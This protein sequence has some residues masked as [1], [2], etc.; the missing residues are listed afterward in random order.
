M[1][2]GNGRGAAPQVLVVGAGPV[3]LAAALALRAHGVPVTVLEAEPKDR[4]RPGSRALF[5]HRESLSALDRIRPG[6][7]TEISRYGVV[8]RTRRTLHRG[9]QVFAQTFPPADPRRLPPFT[10]LRQLDTE[11]FLLDACRPAGVTFEWGARIG[12]VTVNSREV[13]LA[14]ADGRSWTAPYVIG[15]DGARS[16]LRG[17]LGIPLQGPRSEGYHVVVDVAE[18]DDEP[19]PVERVFHY[20]HPRLG[21]RTVLRV[22][23]AGGFQLDLQCRNDDP[24]EAY[25]TREAAQQW[26]PAVVG[27]GYADRILWVSTYRFRQAV[28]ASFTDARRRVLLV[29]E[30][31]HL[32]PPFGA[33]G[34]N[35]G[36][37]DAETAAN[38]VAAA[39]AEP[40]RAVKAVDR[41]AESR[42]AAA[43]FN[44]QAAG[45]A[46]THLRPGRVMRAKQH[47]A[48]LLAPVVGGC[49]SWLEHAPYGPRHGSPANPTHRY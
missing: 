49:G 17:A 15:A 46:L 6:L 43:V 1:R 14:A 18:R 12:D 3:G 28:A 4:V 5:V 41:F 36:I 11:R 16:V 34:M 7:G 26:L 47:A 19:L 44:S 37:A 32:F 10:S 35:S 31:A 25:G 22:P 48:A 38:A 2:P 24:P 9:R 30:A 45:E 21:G 40:G 29:G 20:E 42:H 33:R 13:T 8:W 23:F 27:D 39:V